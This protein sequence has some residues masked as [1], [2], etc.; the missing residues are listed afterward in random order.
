MKTKKKKKKKEKKIRVDWDKLLEF[1]ARTL[2][3]RIRLEP[4][5]LF[6]SETRWSRNC[7]SRGHPS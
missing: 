5:V 2:I 7:P 6:I 4:M 3:L 1:V